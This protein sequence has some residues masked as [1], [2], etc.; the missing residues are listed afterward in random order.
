MKPKWKSRPDIKSGDIIGKP[1]GWTPENDLD[2][3]MVCPGCGAVIDMRDLGI[4]FQHAGEL[5]HGPRAQ[6][7]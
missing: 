3:F 5:P 7:S 1:S 4:A 2:H 6:K